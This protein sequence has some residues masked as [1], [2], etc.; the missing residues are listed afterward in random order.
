ML[1]IKEK[2]LLRRDLGLARSELE[3]LRQ[4]LEQSYCVFNSTSDPELLEASILEISALRSRYSAA[5]RD[6]KSMDGDIVKRRSQ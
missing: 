3:R 6:I 2:R 1:R 4:S 5:L